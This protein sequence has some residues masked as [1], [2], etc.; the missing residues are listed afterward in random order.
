MALR[1]EQ[2]LCAERQRAMILETGVWHTVHLFTEGPG[3]IQLL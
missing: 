2:R 1:L 3:I